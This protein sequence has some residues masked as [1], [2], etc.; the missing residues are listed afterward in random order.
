MTAR[1]HK[2][3]PRDL[4]RFEEAFCDRCRRWPGGLSV[5]PIWARAQAYR[6]DQFNFPPEW[7]ADDHGPRCT[8]FADRC[9]PLDA[10]APCRDTPDL[11]ERRV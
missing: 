10:P 9:R 4:W 8:A 6:P 11:F 3:A 5:C 2:P 1:P 7:I